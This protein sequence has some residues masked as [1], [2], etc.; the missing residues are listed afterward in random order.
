[1]KIAFFSAKPYDKVFF[2]RYNTD[3]NLEIEY[4]ETHLGKVIDAKG[5]RGRYLR[6]YTR[7]STENQSNQYTEIEVY[8]RACQ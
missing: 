1:M 4:Y 7:G 6:C 8:G 3:T 2:D 5:V